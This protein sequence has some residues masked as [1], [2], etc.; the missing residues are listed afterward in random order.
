MGDA[1]GKGDSSVAL[2]AETIS[3][4]ATMKDSPPDRRCTVAAGIR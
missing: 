2:H 3:A 1:E 4:K